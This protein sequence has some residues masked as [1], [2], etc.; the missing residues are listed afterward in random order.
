MYIHIYIYIYST[1]TT[2]N[3]NFNTI[4]IYIYTH[5]SRPWRNLESVDGPWRY[6]RNYI[7]NITS[8]SRPILSAKLFNTKLAVHS[9]P[10]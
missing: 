6:G 10:A 1:T 2:N 9:A 8:N 7:L 5:K 3:N 4:Y